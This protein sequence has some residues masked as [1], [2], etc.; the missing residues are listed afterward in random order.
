VVPP[1]DPNA[2]RESMRTI[3]ADAPRAAEMGR[4]ARA[5]F[6]ELFTAN[7]MA[8]SYVDLYRRVLEGVA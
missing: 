3:G 8:R 2:L 4:H 7:Q 5:R 6:D 1:N